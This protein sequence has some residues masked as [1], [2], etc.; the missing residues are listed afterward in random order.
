MA[1]ERYRRLLGIEPAGEIPTHYELLCI[2]RSQTDDQVIEAAYK[3]QMKKLQQIRSSKDK[4]FIE[5]LKEELRTARLTLTN[6]DRRKAYD[7]SLLVDAAQSFREWVKPMMALGLVPRGVYDTMLGKG[8]KDGLSEESAA[9]VITE[10][11]A[12]CG[13][14][15]E[16]ADGA[17]A[18]AAREPESTHPAAAGDDDG[19]YLGDDDVDEPTFVDD[20]D[21]GSEPMAPT[22]PPARVAPGAGR[23]A[24]GGAGAAAPAAH[25]PDPGPSKV[26]RNRG[27][28]DQG[29]GSS[30]PWARGGGRTAPGAAS[31]RDGGSAAESRHAERPG[32]SS[33]QRAPLSDRG[34]AHGGAARAPGGRQPESSITQRQRWLHQND[35]S[36]V[37]EAARMFNLGAK[38]AK[39]AG[40]VHHQLQFY[41]PP[42]N[43]R[44]TITYQR[45]GVSYEKV[46][47]TEQ[48]T[49]RDALQK[50]QSSLERLG[51]LSGP[52]ADELRTQAN[53]RITMI[54]GILDEIRQHK[55]R[56]LAGLS[57]AEELRMWQAFVGSPR[58]TRLG[59]TIDA[60]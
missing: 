32:A 46:F 48:K 38:L 30:S 36:A 57:K 14:T 20:V 45:G 34:A 33:S 19:G 18:A 28:Y 55:L 43:G 7:E 1:D 4:G 11:A 31:P 39:V 12:E 9:R 24:H 21:P 22:A 3:E 52:P 42:A 50:F 26:V 35:Q 25:A 54:K 49:Y 23:A 29:G 41:F 51:D 40:E 10:V 44:T 59:Q 17:G 37:S 47:E 16:S 58:S 56:Q 27:F 53:Q 13:A 15:L 6:P 8:V 60:G 5:F 2:D